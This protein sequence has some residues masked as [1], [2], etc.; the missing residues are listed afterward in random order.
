LFSYVLLFRILSWNLSRVHHFNRRFNDIGRNQHQPEL[1][2]IQR[3]VGGNR[4]V[5]RFLLLRI[6]YSKQVGTGI[7]RG[8]FWVSRSKCS[9]TSRVTCSLWPAVKARIR[10][11]LKSKWVLRGY[12]AIYPAVMRNLW[13][14]FDKFLK[15]IIKPK[16]NTDKESM[17]GNYGKIKGYFIEP[18]VILTTNQNTRL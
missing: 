6:C 5:K 2:P 3:I 11:D 15:A 7:A 1:K 16:K 14:S 10:N 18:I 4:L 17:G 9:A 12:E 13:S 8:A